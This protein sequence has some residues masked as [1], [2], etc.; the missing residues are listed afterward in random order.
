MKK[1]IKNKILKAIT[2]F[3]A[4]LFIVS[5]TAVDSLSVIPKITCLVSLGWILLFMLAN[6]DSKVSVQDVLCKW[7]E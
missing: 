6:I 4:V 1:K 2:S 7:G 5:A 3:M